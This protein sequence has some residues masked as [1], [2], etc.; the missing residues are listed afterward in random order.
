MFVPAD[1]IITIFLGECSEIIEPVLDI[2]GC[3][4]DIENI[5]IIA[6]KFPNLRHLE[7]DW[8]ALIMSDARCLNS[9]PGF[10]HLQTLRLINSEFWNLSHVVDPL[11]HSPQLKALDK[12]IVFIPSEAEEPFDE[13]CFISLSKHYP[14]LSLLNI[15]SLFQVLPSTLLAMTKHLISLQILIMQSY[16]LDVT[17]FRHKQKTKLETWTN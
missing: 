12:E 9:C 13:N 10:K 11:R 3:P 1:Q 4:I 17:R 16:C 2:N 7:L 6:Q 15:S 8:S 14:E 5:T